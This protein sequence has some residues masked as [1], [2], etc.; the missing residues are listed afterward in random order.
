MALVAA[1]VLSLAIATN[2]SAETLSQKQA[3]QIASVFFNT[4]YGQ[5]VAAPKM[6]WNGRQLTTDRL[7]APFYIYTHPKGGFVIVSAETKAFPILAYSLTN[8]FDRAQL[9]KAENDLLS[10][11]AHEIELI[12]YDDRSPERAIAAWRNMPLYISRTINNPYGTPEFFD[13]PQKRK[14]I[15]EEIDRRNGWVVMPTAVE[16][17]IY[18]PELYRPITLDD[19]TG[20]E[21]EEEVP[22]AFFEEFLEEIRQEE[23]TR[24]ASLEEILS[25]TKPVVT[26]LGGAH[27]NIYIPE[28]VRM[29]RIYDLHGARRMEK[30]ITQSNQVNV[31]LS[32]MPQGFYVAMILAESGK[33]YGL[34][35]YR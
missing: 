20:E 13:L 28:N 24:A 26:I 12:R 22:F 34:K 9:G 27:F 6:V 3:S 1:G 10:Q 4:C 16:F 2:A 31:D 15:I 7:F 29:L 32:N 25:P 21:V 30:Y 5:Y 23:L 33:I 19:I 8:S 17:N 35:L 18:D 14:D 11:Y